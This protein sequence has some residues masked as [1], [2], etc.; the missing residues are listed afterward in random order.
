[1]LV[2]AVLGIA[3]LA[4]MTGCTSVNTSDAGSMNVYPQTVGPVDV[5]FGIFAWGDTSTFADNAS[6]F[7][8]NS[9][10]AFL[11]SWIPNA[12]NI[13]AKAAFYNACKKAQCDAVVASRYEI[14]TDD[15]WLFKKL[16]VKVSGF[17][18]TMTGVETVKPMPYYID[19][20]GQVVVMEKFVIPYQLFNAYSPA[21]PKKTFLFF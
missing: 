6:I 8:Q 18:A 10:F 12:Q 21:R 1:M 17:P 4:V 3:A 15:Y 14:K 13:A 20:K 11:F 16:D 7:N 2:S 5:L 19:G 9:P